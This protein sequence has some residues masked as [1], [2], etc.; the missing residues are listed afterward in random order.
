MVNLV[1]GGGERLKY[2]RQS[3]ANGSAGPVG[4]TTP[5]AMA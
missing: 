2:C 4:L 1:G 5:R 3:S